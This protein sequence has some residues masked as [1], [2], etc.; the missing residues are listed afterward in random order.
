MNEPTSQEELG[1]FF[2]ET[3]AIIAGVVNTYDALDLLLPLFLYKHLSDRWDDEYAAALTIDCSK[4]SAAAA[5]NKLFVIPDGA[6]WHDIQGKSPNIE[7]ELIR[8]FSSIARA[9]PG[10]LANIFGPLAQADRLGLPTSVL[11]ALIEHLSGRSLSNMTA[12]PD[13]AETHIA[14]SIE[15]QASSNSRQFGEFYT[16]F[17]VAELMTSLVQPQNDEVVYDPASGSGAL[18]FQALRHGARTYYGQEADKNAAIASR[19]SLSLHNVDDSHIAFGD[20]LRSPAFTQDGRLSKFDVILC[21]PSFSREKWGQETWQN[22]P[23]NRAWAGVPPKNHSEFA[24]IMHAVESMKEQSGR[25]VVLVPPGVL[26][27]GGQEREIR[28]NLLDRDLLECAINLPNGLLY[29]I[30]IP[31]VLMIFRSSKRANLKGKVLFIDASDQ[32]ERSKRRNVFTPEHVKQIVRWYEDGGTIPGRAQVVPIS[33]LHKHDCNLNI[34]HYLR[35]EPGDLL[36]NAIASIQIGIEDSQSEDPRRMLSAVRNLYAGILLLFKEKLLRLSPKGSNE[37]LI[38][39][40]VIPM[41]R[42]KGNVSFQ[43]FRNETV[44]WNEIV[45]RFRGLNMEK[46]LGVVSRNNLGPVDQIRQ[47]RN[48]IEHYYEISSRETMVEVVQS[49]F[50]VIRDFIKSELKADPEQLLGPECWRAL[51]LN[52]EVFGLERKDCLAMLNELPWPS[53]D[54]RSLVDKVHCSSCQSLLV[55]PDEAKSRPIET[56]YFTCRVCKQEMTFDQLVAAAS[57]VA[58]D[59][60]DP[61]PRA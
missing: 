24:W 46:S 51:V 31:V 21:A 12:L 54:L 59:E 49:T 41:M 57:G 36:R 2:R 45:E 25:A 58:R 53:T 22:D 13:D 27:R 32:Y 48:N 26:F 56:R 29:G 50:V 40:R 3:V 20:T 11:T 15:H 38:K 16:P 6:H 43:G 17:D 30:G 33:E 61:S 10:K 37:V 52:S 35:P 7:G 19:L 4:S 14:L 39:K 1:T 8:I 44:D 28:R 55:S 47:I 60:E 23:Y 42:G 5:A 18:L 34:A 9:N